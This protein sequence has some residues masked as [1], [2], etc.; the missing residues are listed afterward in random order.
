MDIEQLTLKQIR[1]L[2]S[3]AQPT[4]R[5]DS[6]W[7]VGEN[8]FIRTVTH[9]LLGKLIKV[10]AQELVIVDAAWIA[11]DGRF[12]QAIATGAVNECEPYPDGIEVVV[13]RGS[14]IDACQWKHALLRVVK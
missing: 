12:H 9:H 3:I 8:Y 11:D 2:Q 7:K 10:T 6:H 13:G 1:E 14:L 4:P 5:D